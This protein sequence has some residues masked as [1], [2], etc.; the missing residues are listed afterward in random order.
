MKVERYPLPL[1]V[2]QSRAPRTPGIH[3]SSVIRNLGI[4][5][6]ALKLE[7]AAV[8]SLVEVGSQQEWWDGLKPGDQLRIA[9]G[10][11]WE[12]WYIPQLAVFGVVDH[13][14]EMELDG[15]YLTH[16]G[17]SLDL[18]VT[19]T[20]ENLYLLA[21]HEVKLTYKSRKT[22]GDFS[23]QWLWTTQIK[24]YCKAKGTNI[25]FI[26]V[27][28]ACGD[29]SYPITPMRDVWRIEFSQEELDETWEIITGYVR[30]HQQQEREN[31]M[32]DTGNSDGS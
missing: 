4:L 9:M 24:A 6:G 21:V 18:F 28:Y 17:E 10:L 2:P 20:D 14:G 7:E 11:A 16:D 1:P 13:P 19:E 32:R 30:H 29:Y 22:V 12:E 15:I 8:L 3:V 31:L 23:T 5:N 26:H 27:T 25:A